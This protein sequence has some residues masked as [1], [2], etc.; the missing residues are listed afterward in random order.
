MKLS[1]FGLFNRLILTISFFLIGCNYRFDRGE[2]KTFKCLSSP[3]DDHFS[4][5]NSLIEELS[6]ESRWIYDPIDPQIIVHI[7]IKKR[8]SDHI[9]YRYDRNEANGEIINRLIPIEGREQILTTLVLEN[10]KT[11]KSLGPYYIES[12]QDFDFVN[13]DTYKDLAFIND[14]RAVSVLSYSLGQLDS[15]QGAQES[16]NYRLISSLGKKIAFFMQNL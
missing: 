3:S 11:G 12:S 13:Y 15:F 8:D 6:K 14:N 16:V 5:T 10:L 7:E 1:K 9:G 2:I 4:L